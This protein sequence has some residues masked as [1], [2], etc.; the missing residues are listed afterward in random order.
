MAGRERIDK[1]LVERGL[2]QSRERARAL[3]LAGK[4]VVD[5]HVVDKAGTQVPAGAEIR[6]KGEDI[7]YVSRGGLK[8]E[9]ALETFG[10]SVQ[11]R[12]AIDVGASTGGF[13]DCL[14][15]RGAAR[16]YAVDV[17]YGQLAWQLRQ[18][19]R[20][21]NLERTNIRELPPE[22]LDPRPSLAVIDAS[23]ISLDKVLPPTLALL[24]PD[25]EVVALIKP[26]FE[27]GR[28]EVGKGGVVRDP[29]KHEQVVEK[30]RE[31]ATGLGCEVLG[32]TESPILG[33]KGNREF[34]IRLRKSP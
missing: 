1:L 26:Q 5:D 3:I 13:T 19:S 34:L 12:I 21:V 15:Q 33:P 32:V 22:R 16:V 29:T 20:V 24:T 27:V 28:G 25:A 18:D 31:L 14:L 4:V 9:K 30:I 8:L 10:V 23:F 2:V 11:G 6:L 17:G 7:P